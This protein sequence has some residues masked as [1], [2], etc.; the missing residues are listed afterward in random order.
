MEPLAMSPIR[1]PKK[2][3][4]PEVK[5]EETPDKAIDLGFVV[6]PTKTYVFETIKKSENPRNENLGASAKAFDNVE[7][8]YRDL[9]YYPTAPS[10]FKED[11]DESF[12]ELNPPPLV[13][14]RNQI[15]VL[16]EDI[17]LMEYMM[18]HP[19]YEHSPFRV[20]NKPAFFTLADKEVQDAIKAARHATEMKALQ[21]IADTPIIDLKPI[22]RIIFGITETSDTAILNE[23]NEKVKK[24]KQG[25]EQQSNA[26]RVL[27]NLGNPKLLRTYNI[28]S[29]IDNGYL[30][31]DY[32]KQQ[33]RLSDGNVFVC[34]LNT[35]DAVKELVDWSFQ[36]EGQSFYNLLKQKI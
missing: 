31:A 27:A 30:V 22:A 36:T 12:L 6:D 2:T 34:N 19:L 13:F 15:I 35:K 14:W 3:A 20:M 28:Q 4:K 9:G 16:G 8:R 11:W 5:I 17:R 24:P 26:D 25:L 23:M 10:I 1:Q 21:A 7:K 32:T 29:A 18:C 33:A